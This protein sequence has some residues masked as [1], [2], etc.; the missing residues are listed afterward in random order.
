MTFEEMKE[1]GDE[2]R[3]AWGWDGVWGGRNR[4]GVKDRDGEKE[5]N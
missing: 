5:L 4:G 2:K 1:R 3:G